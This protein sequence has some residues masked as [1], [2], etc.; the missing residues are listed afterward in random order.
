MIVTR[1]V[2]VISSF[3]ISRCKEKEMPLMAARRGVRRLM[4]DRSFLSIAIGYHN[5][6]TYTIKLCLVAKYLCV[7]SC[8]SAFHRIWMLTVG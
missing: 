2:R 8:Y 5:F 1:G 4:L 7:Y 6:E 3:I